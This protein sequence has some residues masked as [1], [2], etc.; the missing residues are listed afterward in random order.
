MDFAAEAGTLLVADRSGGLYRFDRRGKVTALSRGFHEIR[1]LTWAD[2]GNT[3]TAVLG[4][5]RIV[6]LAQDLS[7]E[8]SVELSET[9]VSSAIAPFGEHLL[10]S[11]ANGLNYL[12]RSDRKRLARFETARPIRFARFL[13]SEPACILAAEYGFVG[14]FDFQGLQQWEQKLW[15]NVGG[16]A[17]SSDGKVI[18]LALYGHGIQKYTPA[19]DPTGTYMVEGTPHT[20]GVSETGHRLAVG[21]LENHLYWI[22]AAGQMLWAGTAPQAIKFLAAAPVGETLIVGYEEGRLE[23]LQWG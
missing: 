4:E 18:A 3:G 21:T 1:G 8:W 23:A 16:M 10:V 11:L 17:V 20:I 22:D 5:N 15:S 12:L 13:H 6:F 7:I 9:I 19:G 2:R 14:K